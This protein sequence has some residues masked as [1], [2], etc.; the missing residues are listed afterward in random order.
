MHYNS[1]G[2]LKTQYCS[3]EWD[4]LVVS[5][6]IIQL[7]LREQYGVSV[8]TKSQVD[9]VRCSLA[10]FLHLLRSSSSSHWPLAWTIE[11]FDRKREGPLCGHNKPIRCFVWPSVC[12]CARCAP[13]P[14]S[15]S[16]FFLP[17]SFLHLGPARLSSTQVDTKRAH[18][19]PSAAFTC[20]LL[21]KKKMHKSCI[22]VGRRGQMQMEK[23]RLHLRNTSPPPVR[24]LL[25]FVPVTAAH[26]SRPGQASP[27]LVG[28]AGRSK[29]GGGRT[30]ITSTDNYW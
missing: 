20:A 1:I 25:A 5:I 11:T 19:G 9:A 10:R 27:N 7:V 23:T 17:S 30:D 16:L 21:K 3:S 12:V 4:Q 26:K 15:R 14:P 18:T 2:S 24:P 13:P 28:R 6:V 22:A 8:C 29:A